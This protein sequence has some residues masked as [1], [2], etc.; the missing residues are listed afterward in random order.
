[1]II[2]QEKS[3]LLERVYEP[4]LSQ[5]HNGQKNNVVILKAGLLFKQSRLQM[6]QRTALPFQ[7]QTLLLGHIYHAS[8]GESTRME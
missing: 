5:R 4:M 8:P 1:M 3:S 7:N 2:K 6:F